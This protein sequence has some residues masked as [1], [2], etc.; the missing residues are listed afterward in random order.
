MTPM[1]FTSK[2]LVKSSGCIHSVGPIGTDLPALF[3]RPQRPA[4]RKGSEALKH[5][6]AL[7]KVGE[8]Y[9]FYTVESNLSKT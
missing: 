3:T 4:Q 1:R 5:R 8:D 7:N 9:S 2:I 6:V